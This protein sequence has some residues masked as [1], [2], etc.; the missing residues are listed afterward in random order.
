VLISLSCA[1]ME[2]ANNPD[3]NAVLSLLAALFLDHIDVGM[4]LALTTSPHAQP[5]K[6]A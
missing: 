2:V 3:H 6:P 5:K 1:V 4:V